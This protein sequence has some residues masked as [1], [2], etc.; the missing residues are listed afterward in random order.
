MP[1]SSVNHSRKSSG[2]GVAAKE[3]G[4]M[5]DLPDIELI[6][7]SQSGDQDAFGQLVA[8]YREKAFWIAYNMLGSVEDARDVAQD[9][10]IRVYQAIA[11]YNRKYKFTTWLY[12]IVTN[13]SIDV[14]RKRGKRQSITLDAV[15]EPEGDFDSPVEDYARRETCVNVHEVL[16]RLE[17]KYHAVLVLRDIEGM[18]CKQIATIIG[19][20]HATARWRLH[21][22]RLQFKGIWEKTYYREGEI[23]EMP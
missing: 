11:S 5:G 18:S 23:Y 3:N 21:Q 19:T 1:V 14:L 16:K 22:A 15:A 7:K 17:P 9:A 12:Q 6:L 13:R 8:R 2:S 20:T 4:T 10:F